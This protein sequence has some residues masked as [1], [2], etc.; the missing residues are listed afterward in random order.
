MLNDPSSVD[1]I[2][3][4]ILQLIQQWGITYEDN[5][6]HPLYN[7][8]YTALKGRRDDF[9]DE[10][11]VR[12]KLKKTSKKTPSKSVQFQEQISEPK[13]LSHS[14]LDEVPVQDRTYEKKSK[15]SK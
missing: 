9:P 8:V 12:A 14:P 2:K 13:A 4:K 3:K 15:K 7:Q 10:Q 5:S 1:Q 6:N 11:E